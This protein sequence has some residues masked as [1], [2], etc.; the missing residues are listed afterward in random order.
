MARD[1]HGMAHPKTNGKRPFLKIND[2]LGT[3]TNIIGI[4]TAIVGI[5]VNQNGG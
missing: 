2:P 1:V 4:I 5:I 3:V